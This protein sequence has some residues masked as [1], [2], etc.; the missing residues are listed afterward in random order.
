M[1][2]KEKGKMRS[3]NGWKVTTHYLVS[4]SGNMFYFEMSNE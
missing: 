2:F 3:S 1:F 4:F